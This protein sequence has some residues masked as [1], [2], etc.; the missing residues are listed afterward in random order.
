[1]WVPWMG[2]A[3][4]GGAGGAGDCGCAAVATAMKSDA[5]NTERLSRIGG[6]RSGCGLDL[7]IQDR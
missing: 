5:K 2:V 4:A 3:G 1:M 7:H 6:F